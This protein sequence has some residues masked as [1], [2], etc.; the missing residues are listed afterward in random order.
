M[1]ANKLGNRAQL[2]ERMPL[3]RLGASLSHLRP[4]S[5]S[6]QPG[7]IKRPP[8]KPKEHNGAT[9]LS[10]LPLLEGPERSKHPPFVEAMI[11][12]CQSPTSATNG[13]YLHHRPLRMSFVVG[14]TRSFC[15]I[16]A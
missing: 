15:S 5:T 11:Q 16:M 3:L 13:A 4:R 2:R 14:E 1:Q 6:G 12:S 10:D 9:P 8:L 7:K